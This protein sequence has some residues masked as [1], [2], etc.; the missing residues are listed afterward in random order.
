MSGADGNRG[1]AEGIKGTVAYNGVF[2]KLTAMNTASTTQYM[3]LS[4]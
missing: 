4:P 2:A 1:V 3:H